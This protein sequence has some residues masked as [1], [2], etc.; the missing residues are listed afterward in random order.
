MH[1]DDGLASE[2]PQFS[3]FHKPS[4]GQ[5]IGEMVYVGG[6]MMALGYIARRWI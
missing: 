1:Q 3:D 2:P 5:K 4:K 6:G